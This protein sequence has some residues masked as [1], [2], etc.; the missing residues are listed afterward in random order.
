MKNRRLYSGILLGFVLLGL[1][2]CGKKGQEEK[3]EPAETVEAVETGKKAVSTEN[4]GSIKIPAI[5]DQG[6]ETDAESVYLAFLQGEKSA[7]V[8]DDEQA[9]PK[10]NYTISEMADA[11]SEDFRKEDMPDTL[12]STSYS[13]IDCG[14]DGEPELALK[15]DFVNPD[16]YDVSSEYLIFKAKDGKLSSIMQLNCYNGSGVYMNQAGVIDW[17]TTFGY[18]HS[19]VKEYYVNP[20]GQKVFIYS[21]HTYTGLENNLVH[22]EFMPS[23]A[24]EQINIQWNGG[25]TETYTEEIYN[26]MEYSDSFDDEMYDRY[27]GN[28]RYVFYNEQGECENPEDEILSLYHFYGIMIEEE[29]SLD[30]DLLNYKKGMGLTDEIYCADEVEWTVWDSE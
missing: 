21:I 22:E 11:L 13:V 4:Q 5:Q 7:V 24:R 25:G 26:T 15:L 29:D 23:S 16:T 8:E 27:L 18:T 17:T 2:G 9:F 6:Q 1:T 28:N 20:E 10:G 14:L 19:F 3:T 30:E 12:L